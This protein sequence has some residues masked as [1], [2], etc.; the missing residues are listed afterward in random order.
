MAQPARNSSGGTLTKPPRSS[1]KVRALR[2][3]GQRS[4]SIL[5]LINL[6]YPW[7]SQLLVAMP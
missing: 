4:L 7:F 3:L 1:G 2:I 5:L 6:M